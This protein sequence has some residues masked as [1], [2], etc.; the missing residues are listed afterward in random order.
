MS[1]TDIG[2]IYN[3]LVSQRVIYSGKISGRRRSKEETEAAETLEKNRGNHADLDDFLETQ[4]LMLKKVDS[5]AVGLGSMG[6]V[7]LALRN[8]SVP[9]PSHLTPKDVLQ[10][11]IDDRRRTESKD[12]AAVWASFLLLTL[13]YFL[14]TM[15][16]RSIESISGFADSAVDQ[17]EFI[18][19]VRKRIEK[20]RNDGVGEEEDERKNF[21]YST[22]TEIKDAN[23]DA[24][25]RSFFLAMVKLKVL[26]P[27]EFSVKK[28]GSSVY[29]QSLWSAVDAA[30]NFS[31]HLGPMHAN[32]VIG[33]GE[34]ED[35]L[36]TALP[37]Q[38]EAVAY[39]EGN[40]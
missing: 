1:P 36:K 5:F 29:R 15:E 6:S 7:Y 19:E 25:S 27:T 38:D 30:S 40:E 2:L 26:E 12:A 8:P 39:K 11:L 9:A 10:E 22:L 4:G 21:V 14:Y 33:G 3:L 31:R 37:E 35:V 32:G 24:R 28:S 20:M 17:E 18:E 16:G 13:F 23:V 34:I